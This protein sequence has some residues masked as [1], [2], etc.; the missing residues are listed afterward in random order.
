MLPI[1]VIVDIVVV[2]VVMMA[3]VGGIDVL[4]SSS[5]TDLIQREQCDEIIHIDLHS[6][7]LIGDVE[8]LQGG[9]QDHYFMF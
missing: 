3:T 4:D 6:A 8:S 5:F 7:C 9:S 2:V 1:V